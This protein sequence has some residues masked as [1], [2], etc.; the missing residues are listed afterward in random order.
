[1]ST[2]VFVLLIV[3]LGATYVFGAYVLFPGSKFGI[4]EYSGRVY[5]Y[6][7]SRR[8]TE[9]SSWRLLCLLV[10]LANLWF[11]VYL[12]ETLAK[13]LGHAFWLVGPGFLLLGIPELFLAFDDCKPAGE[14]K[15]I[16]FT[17]PSIDCVPGE[18]SGSRVSVGSTGLII[19]RDARR[20]NV[21]PSSPAGVEVL[22]FSN[23]TNYRRL[24]TGAAAVEF[25]VT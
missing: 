22:P 4:G 5:N 21:V 12:W 17:E 13:K 14:G 15:T 11:V 20:S 23:G 9:I 10:R 6:V 24:P 1:M 2:V 25:L 8:C 3:A 19:G 16:S 7:L 18:F